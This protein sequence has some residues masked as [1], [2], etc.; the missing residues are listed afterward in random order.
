MQNHDMSRTIPYILPLVSITIYGRT[1]NGKVNE[2]YANMH[3]FPG[4]AQLLP[5]RPENE[6]TANRVL[7]HV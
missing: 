1:H 7:T 2:K 3:E 6:Q 5:K 4:G